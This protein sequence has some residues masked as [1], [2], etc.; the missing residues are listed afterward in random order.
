MP[1]ALLLSLEL[2]LSVDILLL[3][4][5]LLLLSVEVL[6]LRSRAA[7]VNPATSRYTLRVVIS[8]DMLL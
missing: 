8:V 2:L 6:L 5:L 1:V 7:A 4:E 3:S